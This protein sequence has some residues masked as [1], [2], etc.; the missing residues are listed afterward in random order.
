MNVQGRFVGA[1][2][3]RTHGHDARQIMVQSGRIVG[4]FKF[5]VEGLRNTLGGHRVA[6]FLGTSIWLLYSFSKLACLGESLAQASVPFTYSVSL[7]F[8]SGPDP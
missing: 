8:V 4:E 5:M 3:C 1:T 2:T 6:F 7:D